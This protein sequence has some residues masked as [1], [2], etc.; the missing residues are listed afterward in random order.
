MEGWESEDQGG[1]AASTLRAG[2]HPSR[3]GIDDMMIVR[4]SNV[5]DLGA[6][7]A[8]SAMTKSTKDSTPTHLQ[9]PP[10]SS[11]RPGRDSQKKES[12]RHRWSQLQPHNSLVVNESGLGI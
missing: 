5:L 9:N 11:R 4:D 12:S 8:P 2:H 6:T 3:D 7:F 10:G 1:T